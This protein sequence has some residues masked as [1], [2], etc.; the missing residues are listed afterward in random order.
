MLFILFKSKF[1]F[2]MKLGF[3]LCD[4]VET[5]NIFLPITH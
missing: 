2:K 1:K 4:M 5:L 3:D